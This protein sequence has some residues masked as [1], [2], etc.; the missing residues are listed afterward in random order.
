MQTHKGVV[1][2]R[3]VVVSSCALLARLGCLHPVHMGL[4]PC[5]DLRLKFDFKVQEVQMLSHKQ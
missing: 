2:E 3:L 5:S 4:E 1:P